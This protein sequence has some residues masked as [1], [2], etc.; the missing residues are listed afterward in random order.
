MIQA[1]ID[2]LEKELDKAQR[3]FYSAQDRMN[4]WKYAIKEITHKIFVESCSNYI[5]LKDKPE[6]IVQVWYCNKRFIYFIYDPT[7]KIPDHRIL[8]RQIYIYNKMGCKHDILKLEGIN[9]R[10]AV[11]SILAILK[12]QGKSKGNK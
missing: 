2:K 4:E 8:Y 10:K 6:T 5:W 1:N 11:D 7:C 9:K 12:V 3:N